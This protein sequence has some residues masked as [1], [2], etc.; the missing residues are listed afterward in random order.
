MFLGR[1]HLTELEGDDLV[2]DARDQRHVVFDHDQG[3]IGLGPEGLE[4]LGAVAVRQHQVEQDHV[5]V[6]LPNQLEALHG[7][8]RQAHGISVFAQARRDRPRQAAIILDQGD[9]P[10]NR[11]LM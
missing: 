2:G 4:Q 1:H 11:H 10:A 7:R 8:G 3:R 9:L 5:G 6:P